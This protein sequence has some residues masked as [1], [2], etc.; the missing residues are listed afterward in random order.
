M[1]TCKNTKLLTSFASDSPVVLSDE[2]LLSFSSIWG[3]VKL[4]ILLSSRRN[5][6]DAIWLC[7]TFSEKK[8]FCAVR[9]LYGKNKSKI[10]KFPNSSGNPD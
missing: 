7:E 8:L 9:W 2:L 10:L 3:G 6:L 1:K 4:G 5:G